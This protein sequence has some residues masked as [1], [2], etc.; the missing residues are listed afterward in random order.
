MATK[1]VNV[2]CQFLQQ[3]EVDIHRNMVKTTLNNELSKRQWS[4][5]KVTK[6]LH[7]RMTNNSKT[8]VTFDGKMETPNEQHLL[9]LML[10]TT[11]LTHLLT[12]INK[13][14]THIVFQ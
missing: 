8:C 2:Q 4:L 6:H 12:L 14:P 1:D 10:V 9:I 3:W 5:T 11:N 7:T 13:P